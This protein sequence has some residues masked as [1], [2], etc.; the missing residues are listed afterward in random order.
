VSFRFPKSA[1]LSRPEEFD[2]VRRG[3]S[4]ASS[5][6]ISVG[7]LS[8]RDSEGRLGLVVPRSAGKAAERNRIKRVVRELFRT[9]PDAFRGADVVV[10]AREGAGDLTN[11]EIRRHLMAA[12]A[13][14][15]GMRERGA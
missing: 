15:G 14:L 3:G 2:A 10:I 5:G 11:G 12:M 1:R 13:K 7:W 4:R 6:P 9:N 8:R